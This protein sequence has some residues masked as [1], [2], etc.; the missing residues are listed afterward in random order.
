MMSRAKRSRSLSAVRWAGVTGLSLSA[1]TMKFAN[2]GF[3]SLLEQNVAFR[4]GRS[5]CVVRA[6][7]QACD[8]NL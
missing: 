7:D 1:A 4:E 8:L 3:Y 2:E 6:E 5:L